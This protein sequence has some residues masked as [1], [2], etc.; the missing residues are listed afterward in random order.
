MFPSGKNIADVYVLMCDKSLIPI[1]ISFVDCP[2]KSLIC[3]DEIAV[4]SSFV[5]QLLRWLFNAR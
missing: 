3:M 2:K 4:V 5:Y 1:V